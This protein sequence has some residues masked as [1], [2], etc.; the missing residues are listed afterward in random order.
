MAKKPEEPAK[1]VGL[2]K[3]RLKCVYS[4]WKVDAAPGDVVE[5]DAT[6]AARLVEVGGGEIV[7]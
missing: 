5:V 4:G 3:V 1:P 7:G 2:V 6:E